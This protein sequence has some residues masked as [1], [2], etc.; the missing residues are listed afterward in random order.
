MSNFNNYKKFEN[1]GI[2][3]SNNKLIVMDSSN[4]NI[5]F[6]SSDGEDNNVD[7]LSIKNIINKTPNMDLNLSSLTGTTINPVITINNNNSDCRIMT[8]LNV[9]GN[10]NINSTGCIHLPV[11]T[12]TSRPS[13]PNI[14]G[15]RY[16]T[17]HKCI[18]FW[19][20]TSWVYL[21]HKLSPP[22][23][24]PY[25]TSDFRYYMWEA[26]NHYE[27]GYARGE[28]AYINMASKFMDDRQLTHHNSSTAATNP[29][30]IWSQASIH[31][32][33]S[34]KVY[35][36]AGYAYQ[37]PEASWGPNHLDNHTEKDEQRFRLSYEG[38][39]SGVPTY[40]I[41]C[42]APAS[43]GQI[44]K[45]FQ[46]NGIYT[47]NYHITKVVDHWNIST[48]G[49]TSKRYTTSLIDHGPTWYNAIELKTT[50]ELA[51]LTNTTVDGQS[52]PETDL[53]KWTFMF[54]ANKFIKYFN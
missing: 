47:G 45:L 13:N 32:E 35:W 16:N 3:S 31:M 40:N 5:S 38:D 49:E 36:T 39:I 10:L 30:P 46:Y 51:A 43:N 23:I 41:T 22:M 50:S 29:A 15:F 2:N 4:N 8:N 6:H 20:G 44:H 48:I 1:V 11:G 18:E 7:T 12:T 52:I 24:N 27:V 34:G 25:T 14:G 37:Y 28:I 26:N 9:S 54:H 33:P 19:T 42:T 21:E 53:T 17:E